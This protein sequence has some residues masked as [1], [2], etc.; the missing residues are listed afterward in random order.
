M[1]ARATGRSPATVP[2]SLKAGPDIVGA[3]SCAAK[4]FAIGELV[5]NAW[6]QNT[7]NVLVSLAQ[8]AS[9]RSL[10]ELIVSDDDPNGLQNLAHAYTLFA[11]FH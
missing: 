4:E 10:Y 9:G 3:F 1:S 8:H 2:S 5:S 6:D 11:D 7:T